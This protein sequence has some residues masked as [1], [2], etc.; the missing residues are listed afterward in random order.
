MEWLVWFGAALT[1]VGLVVIAWCI[2][3]ALRVKRSTL[4]DEEVRARMQRI[5]IYNMGALLISALGLMAVVMGVL[6][7]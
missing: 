1:S 2:A 7:A 3:S 4:P 6:L 5:V